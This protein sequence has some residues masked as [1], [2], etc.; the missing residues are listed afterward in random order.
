MPPMSPLPKSERR[1]GFTLVELLIT[2]AI[3]AAVG[4]AALYFLV[5]GTRVSLRTMSNTMNDLNQWG[6][7]SHVLIDSKQANAVS[8]YPDATAD[9][10]TL[11]NRR[12]N[13]GERGKLMVFSLSTSA[14]GSVSSTYTHIFCYLYT[15]PNAQ[16]VDPLK[17]AFGTLARYDFDVPEDDQ[18]LPLETILINNL[19][20]ATPIVM[21]SMIRDL[22]QKT[23]SPFVFRS[24]T[25]VSIS[26]R[27]YQ[28]L[29]AQGY[30]TGRTA[31]YKVIGATFFV[32]N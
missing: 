2:V 1:R 8:I 26:L 23:S 13:P 32:R 10:L 20:R 24:P 30:N 11:A 18:E 5:E 14:A 21:S 6:L 16:A 7:T 12:S 27:L 28:G 22:D 15:P 17:Q 4:A 19:P 31:Q 3:S 9:N 29:N 25:T